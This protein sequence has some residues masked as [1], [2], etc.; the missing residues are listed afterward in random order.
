MRNK[1][2]KLDTKLLKEQLELATVAINRADNNIE[3]NTIAENLVI[4]LMGSEFSSIWI[5][6]E[7]NSILLRERDH[8]YIREVSLEEKKGILYKSF[9]IKHEKIYNYIASERDFV[10]SIDNPD[11]IRM[12]SKII[13]PLID[14]DR[15]VG[16]VTAYSSVK[17]IRNFSEDDL[18]LLKAIAPY[19]IDTIY[20]MVPDLNNGSTKKT[21]DR[22][23]DKTRDKEKDRRR[24]HSKR[25][26]YETLNKVKEIEE[27]RSEVESSDETLTFMA[28][29]VHDIRTPANTLFGFLDLL[30]DQIHE[31]RLKEYLQHAKESAGF[32]NELT[33]SILDRISSQRE[34]EQA[35]KEEVYSAKFFSDIGAMF[36]SNMYS[37]KIKF[38]VY[39]DPLMPKEIEI[40]PLKLKRVVM[41]LIGNAY[42]FTPNG[43]TIEFSVKYKKRDKKITILVKDTGVGI[44]ED[45]Q[46]EIFKAFIQAEDTTALN[47]G[48]TGLGLAISAGYVKDL[49][50]EL[51]LESELDKGSSFFFDIAVDSKNYDVVC[52]TPIKN[53]VIHVG[54]LMDNTNTFSANNIAKQLTRMGV[55]KSQITAI[56]STASAPDTMTHLISFQNKTDDSI[57]S[58]AVA[59]NIKS[60][61]VEE[62]LFSISKDDVHDSCEIISQ[63]S[64]F[65]NVLH[66]FIDINEMPRVLIV[67]D[68]DISVLLIKTILESEFCEIVVARDGERALNLLTK[69]QKINKPFALAFLDNKMP[70]MFGSE[71]MKAFRT[72]EKDNYLKPVYAVSISGDMLKN[73]ED[74]KHFD[75]YVGKPF[76]KEDIK[77]ALYHIS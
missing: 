32:I 28:N 11:K 39:I 55:N 12:K 1:L 76:K 42:K 71:V 4:S 48:G 68:D 69:A 46:I 18:E 10:A 41:N 3:I 20:K 43:E 35:K 44:A 60:L 6:D 24:E 54:I 72:Y 13:L 8:S 17:N 37:K 53:E 34:R 14:N 31:P 38:N 70:I 59:R 45:K 33:T 62:K 36:V 64:Y 30:E 73:L 50:G 52:F 77:R 25:A 9:M 47:Y 2:Q 5:Y 57:I 26:E 15:L 66:P 75:E 22:R 65:T 27:L 51:K 56:S 21:K 29:S 58:Y 23:E 49:G 19:I 74:R 16:I 67:D 61:I 40:N 7:S 63:Y